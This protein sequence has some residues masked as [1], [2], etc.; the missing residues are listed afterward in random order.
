[1]ADDEAGDAGVLEPGVIV[2]AE[3]GIAF[4]DG[5]GGGVLAAAEVESEEEAGLGDLVGVIGGEEKSAHGE[6]FL[7]S[8]WRPGREE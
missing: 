7:S 6:K 5:D 2:G 4:E 1:M 8:W 3:F